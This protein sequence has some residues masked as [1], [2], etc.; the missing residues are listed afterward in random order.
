MDDIPLVVLAGLMGVNSN[1]S[2]RVFK[3]TFLPKERL[4]IKINATDNTG[5]AAIKAKQS[6]MEIARVRAI[7]YQRATPREKRAIRKVERRHLKHLRRLIM[8]AGVELT[9]HRQLL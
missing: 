8:Y 1:K 4:E 7:E 5:V 6:L 2:F 3:H 9:Y